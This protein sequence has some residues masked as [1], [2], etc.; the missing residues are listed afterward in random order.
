VKLTN[1]EHYQKYKTHYSK[2]NKRYYTENREIILE[3][4][5]QYFQNN[6]ENIR[7]ARKK[8][9]DEDINTR[10]LQN[11]RCRVR[12]AFNQGYSKSLPTLELVG[13]SIDTL[14]SHLTSTFDDVMTWEDYKAGKTHID[15]IKPCS[16]FNL[17]TIEE[18][19]K[20]F[21]Y[22]NLQMLWAKDNL[23]KSNKDGN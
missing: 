14:K 6:K 15:H 3:Q 2:K 11:L 7:I 13:C 5:K 1:Q 17:S 18:Q 22:T 12:H 19:K 23:I 8:K 16:S 4:K 21:H 9:Y 10:V 20:C